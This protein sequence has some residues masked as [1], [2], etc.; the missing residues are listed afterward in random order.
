MVNPRTEAAIA[1]QTQSPLYGSIP[2]Q[3]ATSPGINPYMPNDPRLQGQAP[4]LLDLLKMLGKLSLRK[5]AFDNVDPVF[6]SR[7]GM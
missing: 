1:E 2:N 3:Q 7:G 4:G 6:L 5:E